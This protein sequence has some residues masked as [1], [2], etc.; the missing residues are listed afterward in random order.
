[1]NRDRGAPGTPRA[2]PRRDRAGR[3]R[4][5]THG[6]PCRMSN[7]LALAGVTKKFGQHIAVHDVSVEIAE[8]SFFSFLGPSGCG[9]TTILRM[10]S[11]FLE[12]PA[13]SIPLGGRDLAG[14]TPNRRPTALIFQNLALFP[15][16]SV[17][18]NIGYGL[19][20]RGVPSA[21]RHRK[22]DEMLDL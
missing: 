17:A 5:L 14:I 7:D 20:V 18:D 4:P 8:G 21:E 6:A 13:G 3:A 22:V 12:P 1:G 10:I 11:G 19:K 9:K 15:L 2:R 16:M